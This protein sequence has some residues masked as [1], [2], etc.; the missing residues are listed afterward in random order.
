MKDYKFGGLSYFESIYLI[1]TGWFKSNRSFS[2]FFAC[3]LWILYQ[4]KSLPFIGV[5]EDELTEKLLIK[6]CKV[7]YVELLV[8]ILLSWFTATDRLN[9]F[10]LPLGIKLSI[11]LVLRIGLRFVSNIF[12]IFC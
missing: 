3:A 11:A 2:Y 7:C 4:S 1:E 9:Y 8:F 10:A 12:F 6:D 5:N